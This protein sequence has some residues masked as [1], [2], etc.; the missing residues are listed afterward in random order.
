MWQLSSFPSG[1]GQH[2]NCKTILQVQF[3]HAIISVKHTIFQKFHDS[4]HTSV[5]D[6]KS[7]MVERAGG[8]K[9]L[10]KQ[11][12]MTLSQGTAI[13]SVRATK[14]TFRKK[15]L[16]AVTATKSTLRYKR[17][18]PISSL[19]VPHQDELVL[20][21]S[22][23]VFELLWYQLFIKAPL[24]SVY[25][26][27]N[28]NLAVYFRFAPICARSTWKIGNFTGW[29]ADPSAM[30]KRELIWTCLNVESMPESWWNPV[31]HKFKNISHRIWKVWQCW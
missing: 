12:L 8:S 25:L 11:L 2:F 17:T 9:T 26:E 19:F 15:T 31:S 6:L 22:R 5:T 1:P 7:F 29:A 3:K 10:Q 14:T 24:F 30:A 28:H 18:K 21:E 16:R 23:S 20:V 27:S 13:C 4:D